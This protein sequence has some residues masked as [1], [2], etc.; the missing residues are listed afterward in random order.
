[1]SAQDVSTL[2]H[3][4]EMDA[5]LREI[6]LG[7]V[8]AREPAPALEPVSAIPEPPPPPPV[9][10]PP[11]P[12]VEPPPP[13]DPGPPEPPDPGPP[14]P[15]LPPPAEPPPAE[16]PPAEPPL[17]PEPPPAEPP[18]PPD[19]GPPEPPL[20]PEVPSPALGARHDRG[21][22]PDDISR[23][24][25][26]SI[27]ELVA[28]YE[29]LLADARVRAAPA[30]TRWTHRPPPREDAG[31]TVSAGPF[32]SVDAVHEFER[33]LAGLRGV[34]DVAVRGYEG[35]DRAILDVRLT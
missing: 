4:T 11:P 8:P 25:L 29:Q 32:P 5:M 27:R 30:A 20:P 14:E 9:E 35:T 34:R 23:Y 22:S 15:P 17:P 33:T 3:L 24:L 6:Q 21:D 28:G 19:P 2:Q 13:P 18:L 31:V 12:P 16:P 10:P 1:M 7:L 26:S